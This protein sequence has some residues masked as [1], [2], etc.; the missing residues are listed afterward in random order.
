MTHYL[1]RCYVQI[2]K[3]KYSYNLQQTFDENK[4]KQQQTWENIM[5]SFNY[6]ID[7]KNTYQI[8]FKATIDNNLRN[9]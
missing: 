7:W 8:P 9:F 1:Q 6:N 3:C 5:T 2:S 4:T